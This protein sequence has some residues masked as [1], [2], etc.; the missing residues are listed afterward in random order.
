MLSKQLQLEQNHA[1]EEQDNHV[2][3]SYWGC[4]FSGCTKSY[5]DPCPEPECRDSDGEAKSYCTS[6]PHAV[7][8]TSLPANITLDSSWHHVEKCNIVPIF[9]RGDVVIAKWVGE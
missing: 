9:K 7:H 2:N 6:H 5:D 1:D 4:A 8:S 3:E